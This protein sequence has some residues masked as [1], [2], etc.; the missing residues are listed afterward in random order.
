R[1]PGVDKA[2]SSDEH[3]QRLRDAALLLRSLRHRSCSVKM[4]GHCDGW[5]GTVIRRHAAP[6]GCVARP[7]QPGWVTALELGVAALPAL[8]RPSPRREFPIR[9]EGLPQRGPTPTRD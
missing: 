3:A 5:P 8:T 1:S 4:L 6:G 2:G 9:G 7:A